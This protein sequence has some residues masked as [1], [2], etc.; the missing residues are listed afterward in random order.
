MKAFV[1]VNEFLFSDWNGIELYFGQSE[2]NS[3]IV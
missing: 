2:K 1:N 3:L